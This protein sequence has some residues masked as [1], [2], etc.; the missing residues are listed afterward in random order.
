MGIS[1]NV[2]IV[3]SRGDS[4][5]VCDK[6]TQAREVVIQVEFE[7]DVF[8]TAVQVKKVMHVKCAKNLE[9]LLHR[10]IEEARRRMG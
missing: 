7:I 10:R 1:Q 3:P 5:F 8:V 6:L 4:C 9:D 2:L